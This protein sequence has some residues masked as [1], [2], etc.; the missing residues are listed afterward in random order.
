MTTSLSGLA[1][2]EHRFTRKESTLPVR[3]LEL[4]DATERG[5]LLIF[6]EL[7]DGCLVRIHSRC[8]YGET[9]RSDDCDCGPELDAALDLIQAAGCGVLVYLEQEGRGLGLVAKARGYR[10]SEQHCTDSFTS[11]AQLGYPVDARTFE[12][13][14]RGLAGLG[15]RSVTLLTNNPIKIETVRAAGVQVIAAPLI[16]PVRSDRARAYLEAKRLHRGHTLPVDLAPFDAPA[17]P[18][19]APRLRSLLPSREVVLM[20]P[21]AVLAVLLVSFGHISVAVTAALLG[22]LLLGGYALRSSDLIAELRT[23]HD[24]HAETGRLEL[25]PLP[26]PPLPLA[27]DPA[28]VD[29]VIVAPQPECCS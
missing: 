2:T 11:Y 27:D 15:L 10:H 1:E 4:D 5:H 26:A 7:T 23:R 21:I 13:A 12:A 29:T 25:T 19:P 16:T 6:G 20:A 3:V 17:P 18:L 8:L 9:L 28:G 14:A 24:R 22:V